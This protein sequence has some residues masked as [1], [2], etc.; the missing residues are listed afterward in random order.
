MGSPAKTIGYYE[1]DPIIY[2]RKLCVYIGKNLKELLSSEFPQLAFPCKDYAAATYDYTPRK[3]DDEY[4]VLVI[5]P[6]IAAMTMKNLTH[7]AS[8]VCDCIE[9]D[10]DIEHG[11]ESSAYL[12]G[13]IGDCLNRARLGKGTKIK[14]KI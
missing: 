7:E 10:L 13:W 6:S 11:G 4:V 2:P 3:S 9:K 12:L 8:H 5:F 1:Y 14:V